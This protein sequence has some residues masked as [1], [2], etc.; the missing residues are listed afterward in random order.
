MIKVKHNGYDIEFDSVK[1]LNDFI[2]PAKRAYVL[3]T[4]SPLEAP[5]SRK[6]VIKNIWTREEM[7]MLFFGLEKKDSDG[8]IARHDVLRKRHTRGAIRQMID[9]VR[10]GNNLQS[11]SKESR[12][13]IE[14]YRS[15][16]RTA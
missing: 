14:N 16:V 1:D 7:N 15:H 8:Q 5:K 12:E 3:K 2:N 9:K 6:H 10:S 11:T 4:T 13:L